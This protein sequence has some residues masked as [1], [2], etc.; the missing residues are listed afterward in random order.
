MKTRLWVVVAMACGVVMGSADRGHAAS[1]A[2]PVPLIFDTDMG[3]DVDDAMALA[4]IHALQSRGECRLLAVTLTKDNRYAAPFVDLVNTFYGRGEIPIGMLEAGATPEDGRYIRQVVTA[5]DGGAPRYPRTHPEDGPWPEAVGLLRRVLAAQ[6][7]GSVVLVQVGFS[8]NLAG[9]LGSGPDAHSALSGP[10]LVRRKVRLLS[11][12]AG[13]FDPGGAD[14][15]EYNLVNDLPA[16]RRV[17]ADWPTPT[18]CS[19]WEIGDAI[20]QPPAGMQHDY[21][22]VP[23]HPIQD[24]YAHYRGLENAQPT[25]DLTSVLQAVRPDR[26]YFTV[27]E[28][29]RIEVLEDGR[30]RFHPADGGRDRVLRV[31]PEQIARAGEA[32]ALLSSQPPSP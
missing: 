32:L 22:Y 14:F 3:N 24:A 8:T 4:V 15:R 27:S 5:E 17:F 13:R 21:A 10:E 11:V 23:H 31:T 18:V 16:A 26:D 9:L 1:P 29:G 20:Q 28:P 19:G 25:F 2:L 6:P 7:D 12:M 30:S